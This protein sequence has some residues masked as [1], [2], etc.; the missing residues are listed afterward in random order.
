MGVYIDVLDR[1]ALTMLP[2]E[3]AV[4]TDIRLPEHKWLLRLEPGKKARATFRN[5]LLDS[6]GI[7]NLN[8]A[9]EVRVIFTLPPGARMFNERWLRVDSDGTC[10][11]W[12]GGRHSIH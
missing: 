7:Q 11:T 12:S 10:A 5:I 3:Q 8:I 1:V 4:R 9:N 6:P 2:E